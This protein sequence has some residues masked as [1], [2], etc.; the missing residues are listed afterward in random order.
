MHVKW[1]RAALK[2]LDE[3]AAYISADNPS[4]ADRIVVAIA[5]SV[6]RLVDFPSLG[7]PGRVDGTRELVVPGTPYILPYRV[8]GDKIE[9]LR[10][11]HGAQKWPKRFG[12]K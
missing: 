8:K 12:R 2:N 3:I 10:V 11:F 7:R 5:E 1:L 6:N 4:A 9:I